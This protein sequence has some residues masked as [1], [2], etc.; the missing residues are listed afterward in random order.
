MNHGK[1]KTTLFC[2]RTNRLLSLP[3]ILIEKRKTKREETE[4]VI[5]GGRMGDRPSFKDSKKCGLL[6]VF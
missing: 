4:V 1:K 5:Y 3:A 6:K 2:C